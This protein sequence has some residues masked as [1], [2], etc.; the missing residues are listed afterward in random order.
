MNNERPTQQSQ[1]SR[2]VRAVNVHEASWKARNRRKTVLKRRKMPGQAAV[3]ITLS[4]LVLI[5][6]VALAVDGGSM[7]NKRRD[8]QNGADGASLAGAQVMLTY[9]EVMVRNNPIGDVDGTADQET[10]IKNAIDGYARLN[11]VD[12]STIET[13]FVTDDKHVV[14]RQTGGYHRN[15]QPCGAGNGLTPCQIGENGNVP[16]T[17]GAKGISVKGSARTGSFFMGVLGQRTVGASASS[18]AFMGVGVMI[19]N[20]GLVPVG[21]FT[22]TVDLQNL[23]EGDHHIL[24]DA[25]ESQGSGNWGWVDYN[26]SGGS[27]TVSKAWLSCGYNPSLRTLAQWQN[28]CLDSTYNNTDG[29]YGPTQH[30]Q[31]VH[32]PNNP[33]SFDPA[34]TITWIYALVYGP[35]WD[36][37]WLLGSSGAVNS[38]CQVL[39]KKVNQSPIPVPVLFPIFDTV[40][41]QG[42]QSS[43]FH[44]RI[45]IAFRLYGPNLRYPGSKSDITCQPEKP[46]TATPCLVGLCPTPTPKPPGGGNN[47]HWHVEGDVDHI[48]STSSSGRHGDVRQTVAPVVFLDN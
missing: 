37:W 28:W 44:V 35:R 8:A 1:S 46:P 29:T 48:Y 11:G 31:P 16:W 6:M 19:D 3:L 41:P 18:T 4:I 14:T 15:G 23:H 34:A 2:K 45:V 24:I 33:N 40:I 36:G 9:Y 27:A 21:L 10:A 43:Y 20:I 13:Y 38:A 39:E 25:D 30:W 42:G 26:G 5:L 32:D 47:V 17:N 7:V 22:N 12:A